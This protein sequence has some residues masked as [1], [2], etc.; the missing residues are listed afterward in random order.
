MPSD[1]GHLKS[2]YRIDRFEFPEETRVEAEAAI[3]AGMSLDEAIA[4]YSP[5]RGPTSIFE[6]NIFLNEGIQEIWD[7]AIAAGGTTA[8]NNANAQDGVGDSTTAEAATQVDLQAAT[9]FLWKAMDATYPIRTNQTVDFR[10]TF[11]GAEANFAWQEF[12]VRN[13]SVRNKNIN[14]K[15]SAQGT[16]TSGQTWVLTISLTIA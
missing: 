14:R 6:K 10:S 4:K 8:Y 5:V 15:V 1:T 9:N 11:T 3:I 16:K 2:V 12:S 7:L 13:G